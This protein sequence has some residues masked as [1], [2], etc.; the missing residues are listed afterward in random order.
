MFERYG[1]MVVHGIFI[2][3]LSPLLAFN[4]EPCARK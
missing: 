1:Q 2:V 4:N 3:N